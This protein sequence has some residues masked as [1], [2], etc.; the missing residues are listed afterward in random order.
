M[1]NK[2][3]NKEVNIKDTSAIIIHKSQETQ[4]LQAETETKAGQENKI[5]LT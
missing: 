4:T 3:D 5:I 2:P 1:N